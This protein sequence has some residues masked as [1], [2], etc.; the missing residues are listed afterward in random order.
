MRVMIEGP[1]RRALLQGLLGFVAATLIP[2]CKKAATS[3]TSVFAKW[4]VDTHRTLEAAADTILPGAAAAGA[5]DYF[6]YWLARPPFTPSVLQFERG[7]L[8]L[9]RHCRLHHGGPFP[10]AS[11][12]VRVTCVEALRR[13]ELSNK[14]FDSAAFFRQL[15]ELTLES[16]LSDPRYGG[17]KNNVGWSYIGW[18]PCWWTPRHHR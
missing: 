2:G 7:A 6:T 5:D 11:D 9:D 3:L 18:A 15:T 13:G 1:S 10:D 14:N 17:N 16:F 8:A 12:E 4:P